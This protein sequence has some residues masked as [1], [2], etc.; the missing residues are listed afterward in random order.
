VIRVLIAD[1]EP[2]ARRGIRGLLADHPDMEIVGE[3]RHGREA[4]QL[5]RAL[6]PDIVFLDVQMP[7]LTGFQVLAQLGPVLSSAIVF[8]TAYDSF[9]V[10]AFEANA[11]DYL[12]KPVS[13]A[14]FEAAFKKVLQRM[15]SKEAVGLA[16]R[17]SNLLAER[18][19]QTEALDCSVN[20]ITISTG[21]GDLLL[22]PE[23]IDWIQ[24]ENYYAAIH[25]KG[26]RYLLRESLTSLEGR[27]DRDI[28]IRVHRTALVNLSRVRELHTA[29]EQASTVVLSDGTEL[30]LGRRRRAS[31]SRALKRF[32]RRRPTAASA[33]Y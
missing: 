3:A 10:R 29:S 31:V 1:D 33:G 28:F 23:E 26:R 6:G 2:I 4:V 8:I 27:L 19:G 20:R 13:Q 9:A 32:A 14:R 21:C 11:L 7:E 22:S 17:L 18:S 16:L 12:V 25:S 15:R 5:I 30:L 24:A